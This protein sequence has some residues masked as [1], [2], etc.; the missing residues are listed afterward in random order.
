MAKLVEQNPENPREFRDVMGQFPTGV[1]VVCT[2]SPNGQPQGFTISSFTSLSLTPPLVAF[3]LKE[4]SPSLKHL[5]QNGCFSINVLDSTQGDLS[6]H[7]ATSQP[8]KFGNVEW[9][10]GAILRQPLIL[11]A[12]ATFECR[13][14]QEYAGGDHVIVVGA[15]KAMASRTDRVPLVFHRGRY[16][17]LMNQ[18]GE[19]S[20]Q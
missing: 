14:W 7:F 13:L 2:S 17:C 4:T 18:A 8:D 9:H 20:Q 10:S 5:R 3:N 11:Q 15:V 1:A 16:A 6:T 12:M 19:S